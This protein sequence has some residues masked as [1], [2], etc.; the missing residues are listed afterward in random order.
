MATTHLGAS[1]MF[2]SKKSDHIWKS[3]QHDCAPVCAVEVNT[4]VVAMYLDYSSRVP[5]VSQGKLSSA[6]YSVRP[7]GSVG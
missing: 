3:Y 6:Q 5:D 2:F 7:V 1:L 4:T